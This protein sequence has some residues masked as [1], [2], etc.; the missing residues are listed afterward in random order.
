M[1]A[2]PE[3]HPR[4]P[5]P[6][7]RAQGRGACSGRPASVTTS[8][9]IVLALLAAAFAAGWLVRPTTARDQE[10]SPAQAPWLAALDRA[11]ALADAP[12]VDHDPAP[13]RDALA[14]AE[15]W[16]DTL[17]ARASAYD[18]ALNALAGL[19]HLR[20]TSGSVGLID[21]RRAQLR[22]ARARLS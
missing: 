14:A 22:A 6:C 11:V 15:A 12:P 18:D 20:R 17:G 1:S 7:A 19:E 2:G 21:E 16:S 4:S 13:L 5:R 9:L 8:Q 3:P 10:G